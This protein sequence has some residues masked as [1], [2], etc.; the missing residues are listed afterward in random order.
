MAKRRSSLTGS[1]SGAYRYPTTALPEV[2]FNALI[3]EQNGAF[4]GT[5]QQPNIE[6]PHVNVSVLSADIEGTRSGLS[7]S[8]TKFYGPEAE[9]NFAVRYEGQVNEA[10]TRIE[11]IW[12]NPTWH[13]SFFMTRDDDGSEEAAEREAE[14]PIETRG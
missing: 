14:A 6:L 8:F 4:V 3:A 10:L 11:G 7:V 2:V 5:I 1:W 12:M 13:G 9:L